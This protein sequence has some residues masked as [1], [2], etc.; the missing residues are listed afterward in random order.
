MNEKLNELMEEMERTKDNLAELNRAEEIG[1]I[2]YVVFSNCEFILSKDIKS[3]LI[4]MMRDE[5]KLSLGELE[6]Q[7]KDITK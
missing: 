7:I 2:T 4:K 6:Q 5:I 1:D 3:K